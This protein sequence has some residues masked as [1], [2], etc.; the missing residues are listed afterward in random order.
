MRATYFSRINVVRFLS[1]RKFYVIGSTDDD[2]SSIGSPP[3]Q[4]SLVFSTLA[5]NTSNYGF[6]PRLAH[7]GVLWCDTVENR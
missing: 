6:L 3:F 5:H 2:N 7:N 1:T 4:Q